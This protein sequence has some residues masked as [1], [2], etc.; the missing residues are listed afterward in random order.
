MMRLRRSQLPKLYKIDAT[1]KLALTLQEIQDCKWIRHESNHVY[2]LEKVGSLYE[3]Y[4][5]EIAGVGKCL[6]LYALSI[7]MANIWGKK[8]KVVIM[9]MG[10]G[11]SSYTL[12]G[13]DRLLS[14]QYR[15]HQERN[16]AISQV[17]FRVRH[18]P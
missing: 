9:A 16:R 4:I 18:P 10:T 7:L 12:L 5:H 13:T 3:K 17:E 15:R 14:S 1:K 2:R 6:K 8:A 11:I